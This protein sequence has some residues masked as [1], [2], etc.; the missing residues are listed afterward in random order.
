MKTK[1][2]EYKPLL[3][4]TTM[5]NPGRMKSL[6]NILSKFNNQVLTNDLATKIMGEVIRYGLYR[7]MQSTA[8]IKASW[9]GQKIS[10]SSQ[11]GLELL[12]DK[13]IAY[14]LKENPQKHKES[15]FDRGWPSRFATV[16]DF[17]KELGLVF[18]NSNEKIEFSTLGFKLANSIKITTVEGSIQYTEIDPKAEQLVFMHALAK[19]QRQ[20]PFVRVKNDNV[21]LILLLQVIQ[22][23]NNDPT[24]NNS[25]ISVLEL[26][27]LIFW[28]NND[29]EALYQRIKQLRNKFGYK[30]S[31]EVI[32]DICVKEIMEGDFKKFTPKSI[33]NEYPDEYIR[34]MRLTGLISIRG[35]GRFLDINSNEQE[36]V[37]YILLKYSTY[38][39]YNTE[40]EYFDFMAT[41][42]EL[43]IK[44][45]SIKPT[46]S[47][48]NKLLTKWVNIYK[49]ETLKLELKILE[50]KKLSSDPVLRLL[51]NPCRL[52]F[53]TSIAIKS[54]LPNVIVIPNYPCDDEGIPTST[55]GGGKGD[56]ECKENGKG[57]L[58]EV[59]MAEGR[60]QTMMEV[61]PIG[62]H[63]ETFK[64]T[65][66]AAMCHFIA[67]SLYPDTIKQIEYLEYKDKLKIKPHKITEF[68]KFLE[69]SQTLFA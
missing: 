68:L 10:S 44:D 42:D 1:E 2:P 8:K 24:F 29:S 25:G 46:I 50:T 47:S 14:L 9:G 32:C 11:I 20:N 55:A 7:P 69:D 36:K 66:A 58:I 13:D 19:S 5:R 61:W 45:N 21:P 6:L 33:M 37:D 35:G 59:T 16:F 40:R 26:P 38:K 53:L 22:K 43:L 39:K 15:G 67:P 64:A 63:L 34:K 30:P 48:S 54:K 41:V 28:K 57:I 23:L 4:T 12:S 52:E 60:T 51:S 17:P 65:Y 56:I 3:F 31:N 27:L 49:W 18:F 62:R